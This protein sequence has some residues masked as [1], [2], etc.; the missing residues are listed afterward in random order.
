MDSNQFTQVL[1]NCQSQEKSVREQAE[2]WLQE[3]E[4]ANPALFLQML[5]VELANNDKPPDSRRLAGLILKNSL[6]ANDESR[7][8]MLIQKWLSLDA[9]L[10]TTIKQ[11]VFTTLAAT[12]REARST[13]AQVLAAIAFIELPRANMW[14][15]LIPALLLN[16]QHENDNLKQAT[17]EALGF[18]CEEIDPNILAT[19]ANN[20]LTAVCKGIKDN[21]NEIKL[22]G[23]VALYNAL[24]FVKANFEKE[25][26]RNYIMQV[27]CDAAVGPHPKVRV[28]SLE[29]LVKI[30]SLYYDKLATYMQKLFNITLEAIK[31]DEDAVAQQ[32]V[33]FWC[34]ICEE[35]ID[36]NYEAEEAAE[37]KI[38]V[39]RQSQFFIRGALKYLVPILTESLTK[40]E[41]EPDEDTWNVAMAAG[42]CLSLVANCV[43]DE[44]VP[45]VM[46]FVEQ[47]INHEN[48]KLREAATLAFGAILEGPKQYLSQL[49]SQAIP[50]L[51]A[52]MKDPVE[53]VKDT[54]AWTL[55]RVCQLHPEAIGGG[56]ATVVAVLADSLNE[57][58]RVASN[59]CWAIHNLA[60][61]YED[62]ADKATSPL[63]NFFTGLM[64]KLIRV[65]ERDDLD[66]NN[67]RAS[68]YEAINVLVQNGAKDTAETIRAVVP[69]FVDKLEKTYSMQILST[70][71]KET[72]SELQSL[73]CGLLQIIIQKQGDQ[74]ALWSDKMMQLFLELFKI[75]TTG[76]VQEEALMAVGAIANAVDF[77]KYMGH[78]RPYLLEALRKYEEYQ[79]CAVAVGV[80]GDISRSLNTKLTPYCD[81]IVAILLEDLQ[82]SLLHR[83]V[84]PPILSCFGDIALAIGQEFIKYLGV[85][86]HMLHT[87]CGTTVDQSDYDLVDYL[88]Q[89][90]EGIFEAYTGIIQGLRSDNAADHLLPFIPHIVGFCG[91]VYS[92]QN[93]TEST[94]RG[95][96]G[97]LGDI[98]H[99]LGPKAK[100][101][102]QQSFVKNLINESAKSEDPQTRDVAVWAKDVISKI[103]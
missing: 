8:L 94:T 51:L 52:H 25:G 50:L 88:N 84:K 77:E 86:M 11:A 56:L 37:Y 7:K 2:K 79:V 70:D 4:K 99:A 65:T 97:V 13:A 78:F 23:C 15:D 49:I 47:N 101:Y 32:A 75:K 48:W 35:E 19:Q 103:Q 43:G 63:S 57:S 67:L 95:A 29:C 12:Q 100:T 14:P 102:L 38:E 71:D 87:A 83:S 80:V 41:D 54:T 92:D 17:L 30:S 44:V 96:I 3:A 22:V 69:I 10:R 58:P 53:Y 68:V 93:R 42:T 9:N 72:Q 20:I 31:K 16:M 82:N 60:L 27:L 74:V 36:L 85:V 1:I 55:G 33:E 66:E 81:E 24:E 6:T 18:I 59:V 40:Q 5:C 98:A 91:F 28:A 90:R 89:L 39:T 61:A 62:D 45:H 26:E 46:P 34:T 76:P 73:L 21:N 64:E